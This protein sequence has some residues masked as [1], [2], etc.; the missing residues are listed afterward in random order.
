M[1][2]RHIKRAAM[3]WFCI[4]APLFFIL[5]FL[6]APGTATT[7]HFVET[8]RNY[9]AEGVHPDEESIALVARAVEEVSK[10][11]LTAREALVIASED[12][13]DTKALEAKIPVL[14][15]VLV[16]HKR[17]LRLMAE[18]FSR[19]RG[20]ELPVWIKGI[21]AV[22]FDQTCE[23][24]D[25]QF[26][27]KKRQRALR[28]KLTNLLRQSDVGSWLSL[29]EKEGEL[30]VYLELPVIF[31]AGTSTVSQEY[32]TTLRKVAKVLKGYK[33]LVVVTGITGTKKGSTHFS[34][35]TERATNVAQ[36]FLMEGISPNAF[37]IR[38]RSESKTMDRV[39]VSFYI[40]PE[41]EKRPG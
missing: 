17:E 30:I 41:E 11:L 18:A 13:E 33:P 5:L 12:G 37:S 10:R 40:E 29:G 16:D 20:G 39:E 6:A 8:L 38:A 7:H 28:E 3:H 15:E 36:Q 22:V 19:K 9:G 2:Q 34:L 21:L 4:L 35:S 14:E 31:S 24:G 32:Q 27:T 23:V 25:P 26:F 1:E